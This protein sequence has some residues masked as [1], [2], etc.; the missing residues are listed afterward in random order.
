MLSSLDKSEPRNHVMYYEMAQAPARLGGRTQAVLQQTRT[1]LERAMALAPD[2]A[3]Y[4]NEHAL[5]MLRRDHIG[6][7]AKLYKRA[8]EVDDTSVAALNG[9]ILC[10]LL[11]GKLDDA[12]QQLNFLAEIQASIGK[13]ATL[14]YLRALLA[15]KQNAPASQVRW[16]I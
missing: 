9:T 13:T 14:S 5:Q 10:Q 16:G 3:A 2:T 1:M 7:A 12:E 15:S 8:M 11:E 6:E 4:L